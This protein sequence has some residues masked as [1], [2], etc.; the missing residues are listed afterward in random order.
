MSALK[1]ITKLFTSLSNPIQ[2]A[3]TSIATGFLEEIGKDAYNAIKEKIKVGVILAKS[4]SDFRESFLA[5][6]EDDSIKLNVFE[7]YFKDKETRTEL[8]KVFQG[9]EDEIDFDQLE[10]IFEQKCSEFAHNQLPDFNFLQGML[11]VIEGIKAVAEK[12]EEFH[13]VM[14]QV[15]LSE[16]K[17]LLQKR[18]LETNPT[19]A[20]R[21]YLS[22]LIEMNNKLRFTGIPDLKEKKDIPIPSVFVMQ[23]AVEEIPVQDYFF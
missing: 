17:K 9:R 12:Y 2:T 14:T 19:I 5:E 21:K 8:N 3:L 7:G 13:S 4:F 22:Q 10:K 6:A 1:S 20:K 23:R 18:G 11:D 16:I 15:K